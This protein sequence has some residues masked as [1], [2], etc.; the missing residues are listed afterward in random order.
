MLLLWVDNRIKVRV[1]L[2]LANIGPANHR[3][4]NFLADKS[5]TSAMPTNWPQTER[6]WLLGQGRANL[7]EPIQMDTSV[8]INQ[9]F[10]WADDGIDPNTPS[11]SGEKFRI[12]KTRN[13]LCQKIFFYQLSMIITGAHTLKAPYICIHLYLWTMECLSLIWTYNQNAQLS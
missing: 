12:K 8:S 9:D 11:V 6:E 13:S 1:C 7:L 3:H 5:A 2:D 10:G 4:A